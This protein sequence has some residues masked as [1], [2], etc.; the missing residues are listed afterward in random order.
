MSD[1]FSVKETMK[2]LSMPDKI[3]LLTGQVRQGLQTPDWDINGSFFCQ[4]W[5]HTESI[6]EA[7]IPS[8][9]LSDGVFFIFQT[10]IL[11]SLYFRPKWRSRYSL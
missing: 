8:M 7:G 3:K 4:G 9:R 11:H 5:W 10:V 1:S 2:K 6:P